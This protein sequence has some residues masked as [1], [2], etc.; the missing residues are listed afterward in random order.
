MPLPLYEIPTPKLEKLRDPEPKK[1]ISYYTHK[2]LEDRVS[3]RT[4]YD[5]ITYPDLLKE[6]SLKNMK[7]W[8]EKI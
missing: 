7:K 6:I 2:K 8:T 1:I 4:W 3:Q 5:N